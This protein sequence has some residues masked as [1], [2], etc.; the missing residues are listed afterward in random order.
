[1]FKPC[2]LFVCAVL[3]AAGAGA[4]EIG[5]VLI[6][7]NSIMKHGVAPQ[8]GWNTDWGMAATAEEKDYA[9]LLYRKICD[10]VKQEKAPELQLARISNEKE[11]KGWDALKGNDADVIV[12]Q[13]S[14]NYRGKKNKEEF[15]NNYSQMIRDLRGDRDPIIVCLTNWGGGA[16]NEM[17]RAAAAENGVLAVDLAPLAADPANRAGSEGHFKNGG[18]NWHPGDRG[19]AKIAEATFAA[20]EKPLREKVAK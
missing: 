19:M 17:I 15:Q 10:Q 5:K 16:L 3:F 2:L 14:D 6:I 11:M 8:L 13:I 9:H 4:G 18:V 20:I 1:M 7:G 12:I